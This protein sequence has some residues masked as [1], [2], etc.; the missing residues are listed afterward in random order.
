ME[1]KSAFM[2][3]HCQVQT[4]TKN[5]NYDQHKSFLKLSSDNNSKVTTN[6]ENEKVIDASSTVNGKGNA[7]LTLFRSNE[8]DNELLTA[9]KGVTGIVAL[10][11]QSNNVIETSEV[12][13]NTLEDSVREVYLT[14]PGEDDGENDVIHT[15]DNNVTP[16]I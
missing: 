14:E 4:K 1:I 15:F 12:G 9:D 5:L 13:D 2:R 7:S 16:V 8:V 6:K 3:R 11:K 10:E